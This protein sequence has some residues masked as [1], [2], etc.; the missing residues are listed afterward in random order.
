MHKENFQQ[1]DQDAAKVT[2]LAINFSPN[3]EE[4]RQTVRDLKTQVGDSGKQFLP[5]IELTTETKI[6]P[7]AKEFVDTFKEKGP[8]AAMEAIR[9]D[10][11]TYEQ[12]Q[13]SNMKHAAKFDEETSTKISHERSAERWETIKKELCQADPNAIEKLKVAYLDSTLKA[14]SN[15]GGHY[16]NLD[17]YG[18]SAKS[19]FEHQKTNGTSP[20]VRE[21][22][23]EIAKDY[24]KISD[25]GDKNN[26]PLRISSR[27]L[28]SYRAAQE[29]L[30][31]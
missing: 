9:N 21:F 19:H 14:M 25:P 16:G 27:E 28:Q 10:L 26:D 29:K 17:Q 2:E 4:Q 8:K 1:S 23:G 5:A 3:V 18:V 7:I 12:D 31:H 30:W 6:D 20:M 15:A 11:R 13:F 22:A 24:T